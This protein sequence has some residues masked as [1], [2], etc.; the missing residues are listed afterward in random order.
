MLRATVRRAIRSASE[1][2][3]AV[4]AAHRSLR[5]TLFVTRVKALAAWVGADVDVDVHPDAAVG[6]VVLDVWPGTHSEIRIGAGARIEDGVKLSL[7]GGTFSV[8]AGTDV[9]RHCTFHVGGSL[10]IGA[11]CLIS[12]G[13]CVHCATAVSVADLTIVG[14]YTTIADS[15]HERTPP[16]IPV[17]HS[18]RPDPVAIGANVW[19][20]AHATVTSGV[21]IGDQC[22]IGSGAVVTRDVPDG[23]LAA[24]VP[25][26]LIRELE[27]SS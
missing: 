26:K 12:T 5:H 14:E 22:F 11:G 6:H 1:Q 7:R 9:R 4:E 16:G 23:W 2:R 19:V 13:V 8:G 27:V 10:H 3:P 17:R 24:G 25:A 18:V 21:R 20:G 15:A